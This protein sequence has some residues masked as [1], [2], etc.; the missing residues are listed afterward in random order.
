[1]LLRAFERFFPL[2]GRRIVISY[3]KTSGCTKTALNTCVLMSAGDLIAQIFI[4]KKSFKDYDA[5]RTIRFGFVGL[6]IAGPSMHYWY[7][8]LDKV[9]ITP[10]KCLKAATKKT[11]LDQ[12]VFLPVYLGGYIGV[13]GALR[14]EKFKEINEKITRDF[15]PLLIN[16]YQIWPVVQILNFHY[17]PLK[18]RIFLINIVGLAWNTYIGYCAETK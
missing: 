5:Q 13:M 1:M 16:S 12:L 14:N 8:W 18:Y 9:I 4:E 6:F 17:V 11:L 2:T 15:S 7:R 10:K 3:E